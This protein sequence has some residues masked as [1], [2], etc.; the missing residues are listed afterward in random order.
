LVPAGPVNAET[1][2][3]KQPFLKRKSWRKEHFIPIQKT[4]SEESAMKFPS[5]PYTVKNIV[6]PMGNWESIFK[7]RGTV[8]SQPQENME[9]VIKLLKKEG[10]KRVLDLGCGSGR[11]T[12][13]LA[14]AGF[15]VC[16]TDISKEGIKLTQK[17]LEKENLRANIKIASCYERF[18]FEDNFFDAVISTQV[19]HHN[20]HEKVKFCISEIERV[21]KKRGI[22]FITVPANKN[23]GKNSQ[24]TMPEP[25]TYAPQDGDEKGLPHFI[26]NRNLLRKDFSHFKILD[27][28]REK[29]N[30]LYSGNHLCL[31]GKLEKTG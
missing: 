26:Y 3:S 14:K 10:V 16:A 13:A 4:A 30:R 21:L 5:S 19:I 25:R 8:F 28:H 23:Q 27:I 31:L 29:R 12:V 9:N 24:F 18:P 17:W 6:R 1:R 22:L 2:G 11:H 7:K 15:D 20:Y